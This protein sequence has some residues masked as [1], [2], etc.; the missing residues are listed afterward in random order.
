[1]AKG[2][3]IVLEGLDGCGK[4]T[5]IS[6][7]QEFNKDNDNI[8]FIKF[9]DYSSY[10]GK[11]IKE[12][13]LDGKIDNPNNITSMNG[14]SILY[15]ADRYV[16]F[17]KDWKKDYDN[18]KTIIADRYTISNIVYQL[19][20]LHYKD[21]EEYAKQ[22]GLRDIDLARSQEHLEYIDWLCDLEYNR[23]GLPKPDLTILLDIPF[24]LNLRLLDERCT[25]NGIEKDIHEK[26]K[27]YLKDC[28]MILNDIIDMYKA[29]KHYFDYKLGPLV[30]I[31]CYRTES[32]ELQMDSAS[33]IHNAIINVIRYTFNQIPHSLK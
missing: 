27:Y 5:Q 7:L 18:G 28:Y 14:S 6:L 24:Q 1:M 3:L 20:K 19:A 17:Y 22:K 31:R 12:D 25:K 13:Y 26:N 16:S 29:N 32:E 30:Q 4:S 21:F 10:I 2:K 15:S 9:P 23:L 11:C 8:R 33:E